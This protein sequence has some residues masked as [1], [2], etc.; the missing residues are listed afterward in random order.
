ML[1][2]LAGNVLQVLLEADAALSVADIATRL[3]NQATA[4]DT[5]LH[6]AIDEVLDEFERLGL[7]APE[8]P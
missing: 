8:W 2:T 3:D 4:A 7:A 1:G 6:A 5:A